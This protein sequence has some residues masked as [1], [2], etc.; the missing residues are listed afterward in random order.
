MKK[1]PFFLWTKIL[2]FIDPQGV[3]DAQQ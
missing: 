2:L 3:G 1:Y